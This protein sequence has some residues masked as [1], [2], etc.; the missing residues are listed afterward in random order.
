MNIHSTCT[1][2]NDYV[3]ARLE[4]QKLLNSLDIRQYFIRLTNVAMSCTLLPI[5]IK[6][7][8]DVN[9]LTESNNEFHDICSWEKVCELKCQN[10]Q[11]ETITPK[12]IDTMK[13]E[14]RFR[15]H[16]RINSNKVS[17]VLQ[18]FK[19]ED[20]ISIQFL[21]II[22]PHNTM[23]PHWYTARTK[24]KAIS[25]KEC[26]IQHIE[27]NAF[28]PVQFENLLTESWCLQ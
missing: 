12:I 5:L 27:P 19:C 14:V 20:D 22:F 25:I 8:I 16:R 23:K 21:Q 13:E 26:D 11:I 15:F 28:N 10:V 7:L 18:N 17:L 4:T 6:F 24:V 9:V 3:Y 1:D 2:I